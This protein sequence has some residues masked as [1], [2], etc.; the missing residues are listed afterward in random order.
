MSL[1]IRLTVSFALAAAVLALAAGMV[2]MHQLSA[3]LDTALD[4]SLKSR[5]DALSQQLHPDGSVPN[6]QDGTSIG[7]PATES[8]AQV[9]HAD[10]TVIESSE[11]AGAT[12]LLTIGQLA[13][14]RQGTVSLTSA[15]P[16][17]TSIRLLALPAADHGGVV[18]V[19]GSDRDLVTTG[20]VAFSTDLWIGGVLTTV[21]CGLA[22][23]LIAGAALRPVE[24]M[25]AEAAEISAQDHQFRLPVPPG[26]DEIAR[27]GATLNHLL[28]Q[29][30]DALGT[31]REFVANAGHELRGPLATLR[32]ELEL[33]GRPGRPPAQMRDALRNA[34]TDV[35]RLTRLANDLLTLTSTDEQPNRHTE[36]LDLAA[37]TRAAVAAVQARHPDLHVAL[38][39]TGAEAS[40]VGDPGRLR[41][42][43]DNLLDNA[44]KA[45]PPTGHISL[46]IHVEPTGQ[47]LRLT[48]RD[49]GPGFPV[50]F[51]PHAFE[52]FSRADPARNDDGGGG[53]GLGLAIVA[54]IVA[55]HGGTVTAHNRDTG[56]ASVQ[57]N[58]PRR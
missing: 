9:I 26:Q 7:L 10:G 47:Q 16:G 49:D 36:K 11:A 15:L 21:G 18:V 17:G 58:L 48:V 3:G 5:G 33:A 8:L 1:R 41:Q 24:R 22:A 44:A 35:D 4:A 31:Q 30:H 6:F 27:L 54:A 25:R 34:I 14:A 19:V 23:W 2:L 40:T 13:Q 57:V 53:N 38:E 29:L 32:A 42:V 51:L 37:I 12:P 50:A 39:N 56:G 46:S 52:R 43:I 45:C 20:L 55:A 28:Q